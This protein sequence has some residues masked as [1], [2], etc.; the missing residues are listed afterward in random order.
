MAFF[1][2]FLPATAS[3]GTGRVAEL[4]T[5][6][7]DD[8][9]VA[10]TNGYG[11]VQAAVDA[12]MGTEPWMKDSV[13]YVR[14]LE[15]RKEAL[16]IRGG[17]SL[18]L[19]LDGHVLFPDAS[20]DLVLDISNKGADNPLAVS[21]VGNGGRLA[22]NVVVDG[23]TASN[24]FCG[25]SFDSL[26]LGDEI[27]SSNGMIT[28]SGVCA[29]EFW[30]DFVG[31]CNE[32]YLIREGCAYAQIGATFA[33]DQSAALLKGETQLKMDESGMF[34]AEET[35]ISESGESWDN[36]ES[37]MSTMQQQTPISRLIMIS[38]H[39]AG[40]T[41]GA[42]IGVGLTQAVTQGL[43]IDEQME[44]AGARYFDLRPRRVGYWKLHTWYTCHGPCI[45]HKISTCFRAAKDFLAENP[46]EVIFMR[47]SHYGYPELK[48]LIDEI[49]DSHD[50][51]LFKRNDNP[52]LNELSLAE[53][54]GKVVLL[55][56]KEMLENGKYG[57]WLDPSKG[58]WGLDSQERDDCIPGKKGGYLYIHD[59]YAN[60]DDFD[61]MKKFVFARWAKQSEYTDQKRISPESRAFMLCWQ[62]TLNG[63]HGW[64]WTNSNRA[65]ICWEHMEECLSEGIVSNRYVRP[66]LVNLDYVDKSDFSIVNAYNEPHRRSGG[67]LRIPWTTWD[68]K[69]KHPFVRFSLFT[70]TDGKTNFVEV[71]N[72]YRDGD[73]CCFDLSYDCLDQ[74][75]TALFEYPEGSHDEE[76][77]PIS[78]DKKVFTDNGTDVDWDI[79]FPTMTT[80][81]VDHA[82]DGTEI[83]GFVDEND[84]EL[85]TQDTAVLEGGKK[86]VV[87]D[88]ELYL[89]NTLQVSG[90]AWLLLPDGKKLRTLRGICVTNGNSLS[91]F[92][93]RG[94][95]GEL[96]AMG[97]Q[98]HRSGIGA[99]DVHDSCCGTVTIHGGVITA[100]AW[101]DP[102]TTSISGF[103]AAGI[104]GGG[105]G[106]HGG[107]VTIY[108]G[109]VTATGSK[110]GAGIGGG[111][112][113]NGGTVT[114]YGGTVTATGACWDYPAES[115]YYYGGAGIGGGSLG[116][117]GTVTIYGGTVTATGSN[118][119]AGIG[120]GSGNDEGGGDGGM[121]TIYG[122]TVTATGGANAA[123][124]GGGYRAPGG[125]VSICGGEV[126]AVSGGTSIG[127]GYAVEEG[128][129]PSNA[130]VA[131]S[132]GRV[133]WYSEMHGKSI[134]I[135]GGIFNRRPYVDWLVPFHSILDNP[136]FETRTEYPYMVQPDP[137][138]YL[139][140]D[141]RE[142]TLT[143]AVLRQWTEVT[144]ETSEWGPDDW[145]VVLR[146]VGITNGVRVQGGAHL[147]L[148]DGTTL[149]I[150]AAGDGVPGINLSCGGESDSLLA[151]YGQTEG[152]G[153]LTATGG[154]NAAGIGGGDKCPGGTVTVTGGRV[155]AMGGTGASGIGVGGGFCTDGNEAEIDGGAV[156]VNAGTVMATG[157]GN[158]GT[159]AGI[160]VG[161]FGT[162]TVNGGRVT[163]KCS[164]GSNYNS[165]GIRGRVTIGGGTV[166]ATGGSNAAG[167]DGGGY[168]TGGGIGV[169][170][171][172][173][174]VT[175]T[176]SQAPGIRCEQ[177]GPGV[178]IT[179]GEVTAI[180][181]NSAAGIG[182][183]N[184]R[185]AGSLL[186]TGGEVTVAGGTDAAGIGGGTKGGNVIVSGGTVEATGGE[187]GAGIGGG[188][189]FSG[190]VVMITGG[191][192]MASGGTG[193]A[194]IGGGAGF[195]GGIGNSN[196]GVVE[197]SGG[198]VTVTGGENGAGIGGGRSG[199]GGRVTIRSGAVSTTGGAGAEDIGR[200][201][202]LQ[203]NGEISVSG[204]IFA[205]PVQDAWLADD[206]SV[207]TNQDAVTA[208]AYPW[209]VVPY[210]AAWPAADDAVKA[211]FG[212]WRNG[213]GAEADLA[214]G[215]AQKAFLLNVPVTG[216]KELKIESI[217][218][219]EEGYATIVVSAPGAFFFDRIHLGEING[220]LS[221]MAGKTLETMTPKAVAYWTTTSDKAVIKVRENFIRAV[222]GFKTPDVAADTLQPEQG[223]AK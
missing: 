147:V 95:T 133:K 162:V 184:G 55:I 219:D 82:A 149:T 206:C 46:G 77:N 101:P 47:I 62:L 72:G 45:G 214:A 180:G 36:P 118:M 23:G 218:V 172:G 10:V 131:I 32:T 143:N 121:V 148:L 16:L 190:G 160:D 141:V 29:F 103:Q 191:E 197:I 34:V 110:M 154:K 161:L 30:P 207:I 22:G 37:W 56:E 155:T 213:A 212:A 70:E 116:H 139:D 123:A 53:L 128:P 205:R 20:D 183:N 88:N 174:T 215:A 146:D 2:A 43:D 115:G 211:K 54:R 27:A 41:A 76:G 140:W 176:G 18:E 153:L 80:E 89:K 83:L 58:I 192:V 179:G 73:K 114:V 137:I 166:E 65:R 91:I 81:Y 57:V 117:G 7:G 14:V 97:W 126:T 187:N 151:V 63:H 35:P 164:D 12:A 86:Y 204:G 39:D 15:N 102:S 221:I 71:A 136:A 33:A 168:G 98:Y 152:T 3:A 60:E 181:G 216:I 144:E 135:S 104:G 44:K 171:S 201:A 163:A 49:F 1:C 132:G 195:S 84:L 106:S 109:T 19:D 182:A 42:T 120:G 198:T 186:V 130:K 38:S 138:P 69:R 178:I 21:V 222:I 90:D 173:G 150:P 79:A 169:T 25:V 87:W 99:G 50:S 165:A 100:S 217:E 51:V 94:G 5:L 75:V 93:Q 66:M 74:D 159:G 28:A 85:V 203:D 175:A 67:R 134:R 40:M 113:G 68:N 202:G 6:T 125:T 199:A 111:A 107:T 193:A 108:G 209:A 26:T 92:G 11:S 8:F 194:G 189:N 157:G 188:Q 112:S 167:I 145:Y 61:W 196:G 129:C 158:G 220:I 122:G 24:E 124:I 177:N 170:I 156:T 200:G 31:N 17:G 127:D 223:V 59:D 185:P 4:I 208:A 48:E 78:S 119:A 64:S 13:R 210:P 105:S 96:M 52:I 142:K 9:S